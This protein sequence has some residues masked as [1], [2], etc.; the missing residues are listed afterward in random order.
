[1]W[2]L[3]SLAPGKGQG[4]VETWALLSLASASGQ[5]GLVVKKAV[6]QSESL[7][8]DNI[9]EVTAASLDRHAPVFL[10]KRPNRS[11]R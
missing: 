1:M 9:S 7:M 6:S 3:L 11:C 10:L 5:G 2:A 4:Q 8:D